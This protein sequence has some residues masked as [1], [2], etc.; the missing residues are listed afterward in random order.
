MYR[1]SKHAFPEESCGHGR[2][3]CAGDNKSVCLIRRF[4]DEVYLMGSSEWYARKDK[5]RE[6]RVWEEGDKGM[7]QY[8]A[9]FMGRSGGKEGCRDG[10]SEGERL[11][12]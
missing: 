8:S 5:W 1:Y 4:E 2:L 6:W 12:L 3:F 10:K 7:D 9:A 11:F